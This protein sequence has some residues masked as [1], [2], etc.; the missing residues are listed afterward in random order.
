MSEEKKEDKIKAKVYTLKVGPFLFSFKRKLTKDEIKG[1]P[2]KAQL[3]AGDKYQA[4]QLGYKPLG[5]FKALFMS[6]RS[7]AKYMERM[8]IRADEVNKAR[9]TKAMK[10]Q[11]S[12]RARI[13][14]K[15]T[16]K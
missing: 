16:V 11:G 1:K 15:G 4:A 7:I 9:F 14:A 5:W 8:Y 6:P 10:K 12:H 3:L 2:S 13:M